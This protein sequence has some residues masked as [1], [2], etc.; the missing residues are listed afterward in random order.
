MRTTARTAS[1]VGGFLQG[2]ATVSMTT[3]ASSLDV[4]AAPTEQTTTALATRKQVCL[5]K[6]PHQSLTT[7][8]THQH[9]Q[10]QSL[11]TTTNHQHHHYQ[12]TPLFLLLTHDC[13]PAPLLAQSYFLLC[14]F[15][16]SSL[17]ACSLSLSPSLALSLSFSF[18]HSLSL[19][20]SLAL[21]LSLSF[22]LLSLWHSHI[23]TLTPP[24]CAR[25]SLLG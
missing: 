5:S 14:G 8:I 19:S 18:W 20:P 25:I 2:T 7:T 4:T 6:H 10:H 17:S 23:L 11:T 22:T 15:E 16:V 9:H 24:R 3:V 1:M 13:T 21:S 12:P